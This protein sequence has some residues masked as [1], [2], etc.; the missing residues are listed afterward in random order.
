MIDKID[1]NPRT[2]RAA[3]D[4]C[5]FEPLA[6]PCFG[7][8]AKGAC[9][10]IY[11][12]ENNKETLN[13]LRFMN[14]SLVAEKRKYRED[15]IT[16]QTFN[17]FNSRL[18]AQIRPYFQKY[19]IDEIQTPQI[20]GFINHLQKQ[21]IK[22]VTIN[23]YLAILRKILQFA[24]SEGAIYRIPIFPKVKSKSIPRGSFSIQEYRKIY[25]AAREI[26]DPKINNRLAVD[27][28]RTASGAYIKR[29]TVPPEM[30]WLI[31]FMVNAFIRPVDIKLIQHKHIEIIN[32]NHTYLRLNL[33]ETKRH[34]GQ[35][36]TMRAAHNV[37]IRLREY[38]AERGYGNPED[39]LFLP[40]AKDRNSAIQ[41]I[42]AHFKKILDHAKLRIGQVGQPRS[43]YSLRH[44]AITF[45]LLYGNG[46]D[47]LTLARN[48]RTSVE[49]IEK[50]YSSSLVAEMNIAALQSK[51]NL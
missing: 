40:E 38:Q 35:V 50:F 20:S 22:G 23:Q 44:T 43:L 17:M 29:A 34:S 42:T 10:P 13:F 21:S 19:S 36:V 32:G 49:M 28:R 2:S 33:P 12:S 14:A 6:R 3:N 30:K 37:Y 24:L 45:R 18:K 11:V 8:Q 51:R 47:L 48:A 39:F 41:T 1:N 25:K 27:H 7:A 9:T 15:E 26:E 5:L 46:I 31:R 4:D 16:K